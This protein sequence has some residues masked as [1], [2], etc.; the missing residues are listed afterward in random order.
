MTTNDEHDREL[1]IALDRMADDG[2][3]LFDRV[4]EPVA[5]EP[6]VVG[7]EHDRGGGACGRSAGIQNE[8]R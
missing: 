3:P 4:E 7:H 8:T 6:F 2:C 5:Y 1:E